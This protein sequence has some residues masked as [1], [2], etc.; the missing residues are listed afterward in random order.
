MKIIVGLGNPGKKF[1][2][3]RHNIGARVVKEL[4]SLDLK[5][6]ILAKPTTFMPGSE[7]ST[8]AKGSDYKRSLVE[9]LL[10]GM[11][12]SGKAV[13]KLISRHKLHV[14]RLWV[15]HDDLDLPLGKIRISVSRGSAGHKG[16][17]S[18]IDELGTKN[19]VRFRIGIKPKPYTLN[20]K[21]LNKFVLQK[22]NKEEEKIVKKV[23]K[24]TC[25]AIEL[26]LKEGL[27]KAMSKYNK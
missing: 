24:K 1:E 18:I 4:S 23:I 12:E 10:P 6:V 20:P 26:A 13:K 17:Q 27:E 16:V 15:I 8:T 2:K 21:T 11:N 19:F 22:F 25:Q 7:N 5:N 9:F 3:T 14:T